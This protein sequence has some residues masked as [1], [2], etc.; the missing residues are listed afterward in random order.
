MTK[1]FT[2]AQWMS[3][4]LDADTAWDGTRRIVFE[5]RTA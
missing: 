2:A 5:R 1:R 3:A 4:A